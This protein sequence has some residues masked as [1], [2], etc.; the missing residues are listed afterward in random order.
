M[1]NIDYLTVSCLLCL[2]KENTIIAPSI[3]SINLQGCQ[4]FRLL[5]KNVTSFF[6][7]ASERIQSSKIFNIVLDQMELSQ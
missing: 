2:F 7:F 1:I 6:L 4:H 5:K 3:T